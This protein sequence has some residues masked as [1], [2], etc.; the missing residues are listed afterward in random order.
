M[1]SAMSKLAAPVR[2]ENPARRLKFDFSGRLA[3]PSEPSSEFVTQGGLPTTSKGPV[4]RHGRFPTSNEKKLASDIVT[5]AVSVEVEA[6]AWL[7]Y[8]GWI[9]I[10][11]TSIARFA[12]RLHTPTRKF[13]FPHVGSSTRVHAMRSH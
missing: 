2:A 1:D 8:A 13:P 11:L 7:T 9:S 3:L 10:P 5:S 6:I 12:A 4:V